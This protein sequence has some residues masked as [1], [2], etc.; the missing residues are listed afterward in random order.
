MV[1]RGSFFGLGPEDLRYHAQSYDSSMALQSGESL[2]TYPESSSSDDG[3]D[4][5]VSITSCL[6]TRS[7]TPSC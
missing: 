7:D 6:I 5:S 3:D 2:S 4:S 1:L